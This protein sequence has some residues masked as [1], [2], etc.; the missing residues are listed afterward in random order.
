MNSA[1]DMGRHSSRATP[2]L[3]DS[4]YRQF[5][6]ATGRRS[7]YPLPIPA[8]TNPAT[9]MDGPEAALEGAVT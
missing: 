4:P 3:H 7:T 9:S 8:Q 1:A 5:K 6:T 2:S